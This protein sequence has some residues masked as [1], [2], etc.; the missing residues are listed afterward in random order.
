MKGGLEGCDKSGGYGKAL[1]NY[2]EVAF[3]HFDYMSKLQLFGL[4]ILFLTYADILKQGHERA[5]AEK[6]SY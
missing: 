6:C 1:A 5:P 2:E 3:I 4:R